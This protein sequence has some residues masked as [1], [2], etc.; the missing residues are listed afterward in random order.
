[1][2]VLTGR[3]RVE[4]VS[5]NL[6]VA[7]TK[8]KDRIAKTNIDEEA[9]GVHLPAGELE[10]MCKKID[11]LIEMLDKLELAKRLRG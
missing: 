4:Q 9:F 2:K 8:L 1:M 10:H 7:A 3:K 11:G 6:T 5:S